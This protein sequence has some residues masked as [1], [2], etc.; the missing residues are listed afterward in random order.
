MKLASSGGEPCIKKFLEYD[1]IP[2]LFKMMQSTIAE[3]QDSAY[4]TLHQ[5]LFGNGGVLILQRIL[6]MGIIER[7]AHSIDSSKSMKTREV[8]VHCVLDIVELGNKACLE[9]MFSLQLVEKLV[10]IEKA[11]GGSGE[12]LVGLLKGMDRCK[13]LS[14]AERRVMKQQVVRKVRATLKG[15]KFEAQIL[16]AVDACVSEGSKG[17]SSSASGR[18]RK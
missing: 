11:S 2:E 13:N 18:R 7:L 12:T 16:A 1:I 14:T 3:L 10:S 5:M 17:A 15:Y 6:Q 4:T 9:R 8:N